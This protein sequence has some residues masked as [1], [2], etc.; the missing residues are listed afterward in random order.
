MAN[1]KVGISNRS[2]LQGD[3]LIINNAT[4][5]IITFGY[6]GSSSLTFS[7]PQNYGSVGE[8][9]IT[10]GSG[11]L[12]W[13]TVS[14]A[15]DVQSNG[16]GQTPRLAYWTGSYSISNS[17]IRQGSGQL[18]FPGGST[19]APGIAFI[20]DEDTGIIR[21]SVNEVGVV[22]GGTLAAE[23]K[24]TGVKVGDVTYTRVD[25]TNTQVLATDG[26]GITYWRSV[27]DGQDGATG[28]TGVDGINGATGA[29]GPQGIQGVTG[30]TGADNTDFTFTMES[31]T[32]S[33]LDMVSGP[34]L[35]YD[36][37]FVGSI[38]GDYIVTIESDSPRDWTVT[39][40]TSTGFRADSNSTTPMGDVVYW[41]ALEMLSSSI[42]VVVGATGSTGATGA[43]GSF[44][45]TF[46]NSYLDNGT[47]PVEISYLIDG[48]N[49][50]VGVYTGPTLSTTFQGQKYYSSTQSYLYEAVDDNSW[51]RYALS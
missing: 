28:A 33:G 2:N 30:A 35:Y 7:L 29:T 4:Q 23:F 40:K 37:I 22:A 17:D 26:S 14:A 38:S 13:G 11:S 19:P 45:A 5:S 10:D 47:Y 43:T 25:G 34:P 18:L 9:L 36:V 48:S 39:N 24:S 1:K 15:G 50:T 20:N 27:V 46:F 12:S 3:K 21:S 41:S 6:T 32:F 16:L 44:S 31:G 42:G 8:A 49:W 51:V